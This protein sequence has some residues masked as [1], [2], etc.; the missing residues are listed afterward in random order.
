M[1]IINHL[2][3]Q[4]NKMSKTVRNLNFKQKVRS[5]HECLPDLTIWATKAGRDSEE[6]FKEKNTTILEIFVDYF[7]HVV[8]TR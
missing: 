8:F 3:Q 1:L 2:E 7:T 5:F 4:M 6:S